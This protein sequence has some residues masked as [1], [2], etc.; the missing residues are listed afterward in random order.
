[1]IYVLI[2]IWAEWQDIRLFAT[3]SAM[4]AEVLDKA[5]YRKDRGVE[6]DWCFVMAFEGSD[7]LTLTWRYYINKQAM[8]LDRLSP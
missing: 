2:P 7:E 6:P 5:K 8:R 4:E 3:Y 1:M